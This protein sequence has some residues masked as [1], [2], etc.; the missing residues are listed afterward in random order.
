M[1]S[2]NVLTRWAHNLEWQMNLMGKT[3]VVNLFAQNSSL[4]ISLIWLFQFN[5]V[6]ACEQALLELL[7]IKLYA[8]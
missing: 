5:F 4:L 8:V 1:V 7:K 6:L 3:K 2:F